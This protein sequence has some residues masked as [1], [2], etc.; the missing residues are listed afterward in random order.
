VKV[1]ES[2]NFLVVLKFQISHPTAIAKIKTPNHWVRRLKKNLAATY[3]RGVY[4][5]TTIGKTAFDGRVRKGIGSDHSFM[6]TKKLLKSNR[7]IGVR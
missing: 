2:S 6:A 7:R 4:K 1:E 5:T 3:S